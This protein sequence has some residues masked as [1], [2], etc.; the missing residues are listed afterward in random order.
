MVLL[1]VEVAET[2][3]EH[4]SLWAIRLAMLAM[5]LT[6]A[7][8]IRGAK[9]TSLTVSIAWFSGAICA[10]CHSIG[11]LF[12]FHEGSHEAAFKSTAKQTEDMLG[13]S[14]GIGLYVNYLFVLI[15]LLDALFRFIKPDVYSKLGAYFHWTVY[16]FLS[17]IAINGTVV[18][19][20]GWI[21]WLT[22]AAIAGLVAMWLLRP[23]QA[24]ELDLNVSQS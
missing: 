7:M 22:L 4:A 2:L 17:F 24:K 21:R 12:A 6:F 20:D 8:Q 5:L 15:W 16:G 10:L 14:F 18:F 13:F 19:K 23:T 1:A 11:A 9:A 3:A